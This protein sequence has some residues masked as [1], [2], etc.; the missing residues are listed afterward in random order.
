[1]RNLIVC[2]NCTEYKKTLGEILPNG[3]VS[4][5]RH[6]GGY[7]NEGLWHDGD[8]TVVNGQFSLYCGNC[9]KE[10][11]KKYEV[12]DFGLSGV[13]RLSVIQAVIGSISS[14]SNNEGTLIQQRGTQAFI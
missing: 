14:N 2:P 7:W 8:Y 12:L 10:V 9:G 13:R 11:F 5:Q 6:R 3:M 1:M 4:I